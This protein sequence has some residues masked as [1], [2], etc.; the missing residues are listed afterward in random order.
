[1]TVKYTNKTILESYCAVPGSP[2]C[3]NTLQRRGAIV[4]GKKVKKAKKAYV[5]QR[6]PN[7]V[8][9]GIERGSFIE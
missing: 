6:F 1:M 3:L 7:G 8:E 2:I 9:P 4:E 5:S